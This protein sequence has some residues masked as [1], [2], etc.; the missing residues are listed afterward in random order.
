MKFSYVR[1]RVPADRVPGGSG[2]FNGR[3]EFAPPDYELSERGQ[4]VRLRHKTG[5]LLEVHSSAVLG[6]VP[7]EQEQP[8]QQQQRH[9]GKR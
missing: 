1:L 6:A 4:M 8:A 7:I 3:D 9:G 2:V 5:V